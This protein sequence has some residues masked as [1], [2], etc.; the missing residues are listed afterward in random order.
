MNRHDDFKWP[1]RFALAAMLG[2]LLAM[3]IVA[4]YIA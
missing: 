1:L 4:H 2:Y 3:V